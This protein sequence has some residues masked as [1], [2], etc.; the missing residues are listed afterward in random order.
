VSQPA[1][2]LADDA[3]CAAL[4]AAL[5]NEAACAAVCAQLRADDFAREPHRQVFAA[6]ARL[7][8]AGRGVDQVSVAG[9]FPIGDMRTTVHGLAATCPSVA[10]VGEYVARV[11]EAARSRRLQSIAE[12]ALRVLSES[13]GDGPERFLEAIAKAEQE[14][15]APAAKAA[16]VIDW[17][18][19][20]ER[21]H[22]D[23]EWVYPDVLARSRGHAMYAEHK[24]GKSLLSLYMA[25][26]LATGREPVVACYL[27]FEMTEADLFDRLEDMGYG[28]E[29]DLSRLS[30]ALLPDLPP[31]DTPAGGDA[32]MAHLDAV[33]SCW[34]G[35]HLV[36]FID[37]IARA[38]RGEENS[39]DTFR[40]FYTYTGIRLKRRGATW[41]RLD[42]AGKD[43]DRGQR[44]SS[45]KGD[46]VDV[47]WQL[48]QTENGV[49]LRR[50]RA[51]MSWVPE[52][53]TLKLSESPL[54]FVPLTGDWPAGTG[55]VANILAR[56]E[57]PL[58]ATTREAAAALH[59]IDEG[60]RRSLVVAAQRFRRERLKGGA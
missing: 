34:P 26:K 32:L 17:A 13:N 43:P 22:A 42:H 8:A 44:G 20:W 55:E 33:Q 5:C 40:D 52:R 47:V 10:N 37:T 53:V 57:V 4:G 14:A 21:D 59:T 2:F 35:H 31:L 54:A 9:E 15:A 39:A 36:V 49:T 27:D 7:H 19:F 48:K 50:H 16:A 25:A 29:S 1:L 56:L 60:R 41:M 23:E 12:E 6:I 18:A 11:R 38:V 51:R 28:P 3:E 24:A 30:Y 46:D 58:N 45:G